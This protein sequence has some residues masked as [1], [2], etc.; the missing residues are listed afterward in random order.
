[1]SRHGTPAPGVSTALHRLRPLLTGRWA[2]LGGFAL[3]ALALFVVAPLA[4]SDFRLSLLGKYL[5]YAMVA[6]GIGLAWGRGGMLTLGQGVF[7]G[8]GAYMMAFHLE[9]DD[10]GDG[11][12]PDFMA[13]ISS[14]GVPWWWEPFRSGIFTILA[15]LLVPAALAGLLGLATF[16]RKVRGAYFA[17]LSQAL[18]A[19]FAILLIGNPKAT[20][21]STGLNNFRGFFGFALNDAANRRM[22][23]FISAGALLVMVAVIR[24]LMVSRYGELLVA[25]RDA[26]ERVRFLGYDPANVKTVA[27]MV[28][29]GMASVAGALFVP[30]VGIVSPNDVGI[31]PSIG[32][33]IGVA[34][35]GR[36]TLLGPVLGAIGVAW[37]G[38]TLSENFPS[39]WTYLQGLLFML[40]IAFLPDGLASLNGLLR[41]RRRTGEAPEPEPEPDNAELTTASKAAPTTPTVSGSA[42]S[43]AEESAGRAADPVS[44][45]HSGGTE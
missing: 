8:L 35:G 42:P 44:A 21:G 11:K 13:L 18:A 16:R 5:C 38:S 1:M 20:G 23:F 17:I 24:Q 28:A 41:A 27:F 22:L 43:G 6:V 39:A 45:T 31:V 37:A 34:I 19:A 2:V 32:L 9:L 29:A 25:C 26:E 33:L 7:F 4:L 12:V 36:T 3:A 30:I 14:D 10:A 40:V 15:I